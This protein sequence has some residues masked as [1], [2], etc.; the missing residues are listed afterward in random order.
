MENRLSGGPSGS[1]KTS[2][3]TPADILGRDDGRDG[4]HLER[5]GRWA[6]RTHGRSDVRCVSGGGVSPKLSAYSWLHMT[7]SSNFRVTS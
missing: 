5:L 4:V 3:E 1:R 2:E 6:E 7:S